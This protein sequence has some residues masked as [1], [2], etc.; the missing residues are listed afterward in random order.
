MGLTVVLGRAGL[1]ELILQ[2]PELAGARVQPH[3]SKRRCGRHGPSRGRHGA[4]G[5]AHLAL[6]GEFARGPNREREMV[7][8]FGEP[9]AH[10]ARREGPPRRDGCAGEAVGVRGV[11]LLG[12]QVAA[13]GDQ[14][15][16]GAVPAAKGAR[17]NDANERN[18]AP[19][20]VCSG[21]GQPGSLAS[22]GGWGE[23]GSRAP[24]QGVR[25]ARGPR[26]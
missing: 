12:E 24:A 15:I 14:D 4:P 23:R 8:L 19:P 22:P 10:R 20:K 25:R 9:A 13:V 26:K 16:G 11:G 2:R 18:P 17:A 5:K 3:F 21:L 7:S 6:V 1:L